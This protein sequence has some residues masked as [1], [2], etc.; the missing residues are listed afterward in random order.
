MPSGGK[1]NPALYGGMPQAPGPGGVAPRLLE[2]ADELRREGMAVGTSELLDAFAALEAVT[3]TDRDDFRGALSATLAKSQEDRRLFEL[4]FDRFF[5]RA[6]EREAMERQIK[7]GSPGE[8]GEQ[9]IDLDAL[10]ERIRAALRA[11]E[12]SDG[13]LRDLARLAIS[14]FGRQ[15]EG[16]GVIGVDVQRIRRTLG[17]KG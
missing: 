12:G 5:F 2:F 4:V 7:E 10:R 8:G 17:L 6:V 13:D 1:A 16:S 3:W 15:G 11:P 9:R 14:A